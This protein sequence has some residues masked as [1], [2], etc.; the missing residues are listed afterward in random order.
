APRKSHAVIETDGRLFVKALSLQSLVENYANIQ[1]GSYEQLR[2]TTLQK[3]RCIPGLSGVPIDGK[4]RTIV[5]Q[6]LPHF[7]RRTKRLARRKRNEEDILDLIGE[8]ISI[9]ARYYDDAR[10]S[11]ETESIRRA[12]NDLEEQRVTIDP[13]KDGLM[14][15]HK[16]H[17][18]LLKALEVRI[19]DGEKSRLRQVLDAREQ[20]G[21]TQRKSVARLLYIAEKGA[22]EIDGFGFSRIG[23]T[24]EY[25]IYKHTGEYALSDFYGRIYLFPDCR[26]AVSTIV[27]LRPVVMDMYKHPFLEGHDSAQQ[28]CLRDFSPP[29]VFTVANVI[30]A[31]ELGINALLYGY[32]S[33]RRN[34]YHSLDRVTRHVRTVEFDED[35]V[36]EHDDPLIP[37][38]RMQIVDFD[39]YRVPRDHAKIA[40]GRVQITNGHM[41]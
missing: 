9:P 35:I 13:L 34:G 15:T 18:W 12:L 11:L 5:F 37:R 7:I 19:V 3:Y 25:L 28:I 21:A 30:N 24:E 4:L 40:S 27:P 10:K 22:L 26:V 17:E 33:R 29:R 6:V 20:F 32:S 8:K 41:P 39:D 16:L 2:S 38:R 36:P 23:C 1:E 31:L 14:S